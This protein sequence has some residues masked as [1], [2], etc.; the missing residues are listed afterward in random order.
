MFGKPEFKV[1]L[2]VVVS[3]VAVGYMSMKVAKGSGVFTSTDTHSITVDDA[4][5]I[6]KNTA[7][8]VAGVKVG[9]VE[10]VVLENGKAVV[11]ISVKKNLGLT[12]NTVAELKADGILGGKHI[13][14]TQEE[15]E[16]QTGAGS[17]TGSGTG[18]YDSGASLEKLENGDELKMTGTGAGVAEVMTDIS[19]V[20]KS[21]QEVADAI[22]SA[23]VQ[24]NVETPIGRIIS[25]I[26]ILTEDLADISSSN[27]GKINSIID[28]LDGIAGTLSSVMGEGNR[29]RVEG[30]FDNAIDGLAKFDESLESIKSIT[31][32]IERGEGTVGKLIND[33]E[34]VDGINKT[35]ENLNLLLGGV[36][37]FNT[38]IDYHS[39]Y[40]TTATDEPGIDSSVKSY[41]G[42]RFQPGLDRYYEVQLVQDPL[43]VEKKSTLVREGTQNENFTTTIKRE[44]KLKFTALFAKNFYN[45]TLKGGFIE[46]S[47]GFGIDYYLFND[48][49]R[50]SAEFF[51]FDEST[52]RAFARWDIYDGIYLVGGTNNSDDLSSPFIG[53]GVFLTN[54]DLKLLAALA[55]R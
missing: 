55:F 37:N 18:T 10:D 3:F 29:E 41:V 23:T 32:K 33:E 51:N 36:R 44:D 26:E 8:K 2:L 27:K 53:A 52:V 9:I 47:G 31:A 34:T 40:L 43:G 19:A 7:V 16:P 50:L 20:A 21:L 17:G 14:L 15:P 6:I 49:L 5:G 12:K 11:K 39:E 25:N 38:S 48:K 28:K 1:G 54:E 35:I 13:A 42:V 30:A 45:F 22:K 24:G 4:S 46:S